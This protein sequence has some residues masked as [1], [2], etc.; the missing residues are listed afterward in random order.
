MDLTGRRSG[1]CSD[2]PDGY[3]NA[4]VLAAQLEVAKWG[5]EELKIEQIPSLDPLP[6][7]GASLCLNL[8][9]CSLS[10]SPWDLHS[11]N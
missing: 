8:Y 10:R 5:A 9:S 3:R 7:L 4:V 11:A 2:R 1:V 6:W